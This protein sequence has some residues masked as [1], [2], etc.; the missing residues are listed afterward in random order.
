MIRAQFLFGA[1]IPLLAQNAF[2]LD[3]AGEWRAKRG[4]DFRWASPALNESGWSTVHLP[5]HLASGSPLY[6]WVFRD[7]WVRRS[8]V[9]PAGTPTNDLVLTLGGY[10]RRYCVGECR[11]SGAL[12]G[13]Q[14]SCD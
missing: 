12:S 13:R 6:D 1:A 10:R 8:F 9:L 14:G 7:A 3:L 2:Y 11:S 5:L 4:D